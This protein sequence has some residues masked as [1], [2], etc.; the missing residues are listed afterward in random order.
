[1]HRLLVVRLFPDSEEKFQ[2][3]A[4]SSNPK[5]SGDNPIS[6][7]EAGGS[8][9]IS[10]PDDLPEYSRIKVFPLPCPMKVNDM[11]FWHIKKTGKSFDYD[12]A[13]WKVAERKT[14]IGGELHIEY[15][16]RPYV[17]GV[18]D[19][20]IFWLDPNDKEGGKIRPYVVKFKGDHECTIVYTEYFIF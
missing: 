5:V 7:K 16:G 18:G 10:F 4:D 8:E 15:E 14:I 20:I 11:G 12:F 9:W 3:V 1:M 19:S 2:I 13:A 6:M 17:A